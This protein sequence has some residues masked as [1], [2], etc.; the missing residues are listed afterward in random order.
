MSEEAKILDQ[1]DQAARELDG[2]KRLD[3]KFKYWITYCPRVNRS[4]GRM[5][6]KCGRERYP[7][8]EYARASMYTNI[9]IS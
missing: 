5:Q 7:S 2:N 3:F 1:N 4:Q 6:Y 9:S 8:L